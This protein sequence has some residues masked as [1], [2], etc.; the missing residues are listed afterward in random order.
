M[1][2]S[3]Q[4]FLL[5]NINKIQNPAEKNSSHLINISC[6]NNICSVNL[7]CDGWYFYHMFYYLD[8]G[9]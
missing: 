1:N 8:D 9:L 4:Y 6:V 7:Y 5:G 2:N 3:S